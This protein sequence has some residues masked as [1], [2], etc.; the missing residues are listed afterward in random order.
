M[1]LLKV[2]TLHLYPAPKISIAENVN[3][4]AAVVGFLQLSEG[5]EIVMGI[6]WAFHDV[7]R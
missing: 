7:Q 4:W 5:G 3:L 2:V 6:N 1:V